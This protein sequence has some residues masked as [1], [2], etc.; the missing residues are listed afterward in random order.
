MATIPEQEGVSLGDFNIHDAPLRELA[1]AQ[2]AQGL[3]TY[4]H[5][6]GSQ[7]SPPAELCVLVRSF[8]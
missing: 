6:C 8:R 3:L 5:L 7:L 1:A 4:K 2:T